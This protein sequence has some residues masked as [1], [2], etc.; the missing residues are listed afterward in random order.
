MWRG[1]GGKGA[2]LFWIPSLIMVYN[3]LLLQ[4]ITSFICNSLTFKLGLSPNTFDPIHPIIP[5]SE[6]N[7][8]ENCGNQ[9][10]VSP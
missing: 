3:I 2:L 6:I 8:F 9:R 4:T 5:E 7:W 10:R 1:E